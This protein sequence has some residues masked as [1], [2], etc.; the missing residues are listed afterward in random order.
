[1]NKTNNSNSPI[2]IKENNK[3]NLSKKK[4]NE[5]NSYDK[6]KD[7][8]LIKKQNNEFKNEL[9]NKETGNI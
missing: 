2:I 3:V 8:S 6:N 4:E 5:N 7:S 9:I 1:M